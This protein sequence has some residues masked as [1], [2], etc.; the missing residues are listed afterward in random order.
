M[1]KLLR[2]YDEEP[3]QGKHYATTPS[4]QYWLGC[5]APD[6]HELGRP[7]L[8]RRPNAWAGASPPIYKSFWR[9]EFSLNARHVSRL[10]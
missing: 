8:G 7:M 2:S 10:S 4:K 1:Q 9:E 3:V 6:C 5:N